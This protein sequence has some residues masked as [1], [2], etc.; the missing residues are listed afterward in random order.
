MVPWAP[1]VMS[2]TPTHT[3]TPWWTVSGIVSW[4]HWFFVRVFYPSKWKGNQENLNAAGTSP[5]YKPSLLPSPGVSL[6]SWHLYKK[7]EIPLAGVQTCS[8]YRV[9]F[10]NRISQRQF[11]ILCYFSVVIK[12]TKATYGRK[13]LHGLIV[14]EGYE[15]I[16]AGGVMAGTGS[17]ECSTMTMKQRVELEVGLTPKPSDISLRKWL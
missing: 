12:H 16:I 6:A 7:G 8:Q 15:S 10:S 5:I 14:P 4:V 2:P 1:I 3:H 9:W 11:E 13:S 17:W